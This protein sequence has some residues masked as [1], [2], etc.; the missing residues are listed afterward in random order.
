[1]YDGTNV[2]FETQSTTSYIDGLTTVYGLSK[3]FAYDI[4]KTLKRL[5]GTIVEPPLLSS[6]HY[7]NAIK[8]MSLFADDRT[9]CIK[10]ASHI[11]LLYIIV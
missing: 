9:N 10:A 7:D 2:Q 3:S 1:V 8:I 6:N 5:W 4:S 11:S